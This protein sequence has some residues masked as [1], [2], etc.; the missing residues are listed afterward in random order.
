MN[1][2]NQRAEA[3][4]Q[5][6]ENLLKAMLLLHLQRGNV[7]VSD[8]AAELDMNLSTAYSVVG[9][10]AENG[11]IHPLEAKR[12]GRRS[13]KQALFFTPEGEALAQ[14]I[15]ERHQI[16]QGW[17]IRLGV[18]VEETCHIEQGITDNTVAL[19]QGHVQMAT[20]MLGRAACAPEIMEEMRTR[21]GQGQE[22]LGLTASEKMRHTIE[23]LGGIA[24]IERMSSLVARAGGEA[25]LRGLLN[26]VESLGGVEQLIREKEELLELQ[27][28]A[29]SRGGSGGLKKTL[30]TV[31]QCGGAEKIGRLSALEKKAGGMERL[32]A[33]LETEKRLGGGDTVKKR[34]SASRR[35]GSVKNMLELLE[36]ERKLWIRLIESSSEESMDKQLSGHSEQS[37]IYSKNI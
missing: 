19:I 10:L 37:N 21:M 32:E 24:G 33:A 11:Y 4:R 15:L 20:T 25:R 16:I 2:F 31:D 23:R 1:R 28:L 13:N 29:R 8:L 18:P 36:Q 9:K 14:K 30:Q 35:F 6:D 5:A 12:G 26:A 27:D 17:L 34:L 7:Y 22:N 3:A